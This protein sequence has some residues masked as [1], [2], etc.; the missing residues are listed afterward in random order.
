MSGHGSDF[1]PIQ[2]SLDMRGV[3]QAPTTHSGSHVHRE[4]KTMTD[5][6]KTCMT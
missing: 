1:M 6:K 2:I 5:T 4:R 3:L